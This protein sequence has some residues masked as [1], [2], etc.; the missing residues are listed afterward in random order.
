[1]WNGASIPITVF[2]SNGEM[3][4]INEYEVIDGKIQFDFNLNNVKEG[5]GIIIRYS[6]IGVN[7]RF[8][9]NKKQDPGTRD[10][11]PDPKPDPGTSEPDKPNTGPVNSGPTK[12]TK[13]V[14]KEDK[15]EIIIKTIKTNN[16]DKLNKLEIEKAIKDANEYKIKSIVSDNKFL[17]NNNISKWATGNIQSAS[18]LGLLQGFNENFKPKAL[19]TKAEGATVVVRL[20][21]LLNK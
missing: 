1:M 20:L 14:A 12:P 11:K 21:E 19:T 18:A 2:D 16:T 4:Y 8:T 6:H 15:T 3:V 5:D 10:P 7:T 9:Y 17:P 13:P